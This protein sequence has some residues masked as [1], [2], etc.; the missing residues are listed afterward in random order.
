MSGTAS[1]G[2]AS[3]GNEIDTAKLRKKD[4]ADLEAGKYG[5]FNNEDE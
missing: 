4:I 3:E 5:K 1:P 2:K